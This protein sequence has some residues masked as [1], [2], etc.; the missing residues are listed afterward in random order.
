MGTACIATSISVVLLLFH[1]TTSCHTTAALSSHMQERVR[2][3]IEGVHI[4]SLGEHLD[5]QMV[6][7]V[8]GEVLHG[9]PPLEGPTP[10]LQILSNVMLSR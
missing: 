1:A 10:D 5:Q 6:K 4:R 9:D 2:H 3:G 7:Q 8:L